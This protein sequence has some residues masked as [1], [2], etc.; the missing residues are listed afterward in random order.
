MINI[1]EMIQGGEFFN[2]GNDF[3]NNIFTAS[4][5]GI[6]KVVQ[7]LIEKNR[8]LTDTR[9]SNIFFIHMR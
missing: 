4:R 1:I 6:I 2:S 9:D 5:K 8:D 3:F 7:K